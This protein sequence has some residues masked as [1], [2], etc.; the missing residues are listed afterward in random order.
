[1]GKWASFT[2][3]HT[4]VSSGL[5]MGLLLVTIQMTHCGFQFSSLRYKARVDT[6]SVPVNRLIV[7]VTMPYLAALRQ[8]TNYLRAFQRGMGIFELP[9]YLA[10]PDWKQWEPV[11]K[12]LGSK[13]S[14]PS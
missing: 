5:S 14:Q 1:M 9:E 4:A 2:R 3:S 6:E 12:W 13:K 8:S 11:T 10:A 7:W